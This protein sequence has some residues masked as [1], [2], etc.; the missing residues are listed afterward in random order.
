MNYFMEEAR[1]RSEYKGIRTSDTET[2]HGA[3]EAMGAIPLAG[4]QGWDHRLM[5]SEQ[6]CEDQVLGVRGELDRRHSIPK[7]ALQ[8]VH[9]QWKT[10]SRHSRIESITGIG[11]EDARPTVLRAESLQSRHQHLAGKKERNGEIGWRGTHGIGQDI[12]EFE[13]EVADG[14]F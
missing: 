5:Q 8:R 3:V 2:R 4:D 11:R 10:A 12:F 9:D 14:D 1:G 13:V 6:H 7:I